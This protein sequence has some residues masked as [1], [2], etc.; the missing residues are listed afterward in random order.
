[1]SDTCRL[2]AADP[3]LVGDPVDTFTG[4]VLDRVLDFRLTG[5]IELRWWRHYDSSQCAR[6]FSMGW[7]MAHDYER[8]LVAVD[9]HSMALDEPVGRRLV[10][11]RL[12]ADGD[13]VARGGSILVRCA[14]NHYVVQR[15]GEPAMEFFF[16]RGAVRARLR[17]LIRDGSEIRFEHDEQQRLIRIVDAAG[18]HIE[19]DE[20]ADGSL[21]RL[22]LAASADAPARLLMAYRYDDRGCLVA[23]EN[24]DGHGHRFAWDVERRLVLRRGRKG[25]QFRFAY[26][27]QGRCTLAVGDDRLHGVALDYQVPARMTRVVRPD[28]GAWIYR[29]TQTGGLASV[30]DPL[31]GVRR[32]VHDAA[33][34]LLQEIDPNGNVSTYAYD[35]AGA[36]VARIDPLGYRL[37]WPD[38]PNGP[39]PLLHRLAANPAEYA[40]GRL[41]DTGAI[42]LPVATSALPVDPAV[43]GAVITRIPDTTMDG[44]SAF[45]TG[46][47]GALWWPEP[48]WG[49]TFS[50]LGKLIAQHDD[51]GNVRRWQYD[52]AGNLAEYCDFDG[53]RWCYDHG[54]WH[55]LRRA[56]D[57][58]GSEV[59]FDYTEQGEVASFQDAG[60]A[61]STYRY[62]LCDRLIEVHR[63]GALRERYQR[64]LA[65]NLVAK[66]GADGR[67]L[68]RIEI[69]P[70]NLPLRRVL[71]SGDVHEFRHDRAGQLL[72]ADTRCDRV[73][74]FYDRFCNRSAELRDGRGVVHDFA[75]LN[76]L[77]RS[78]VLDRFVI[79]HR[80]RADGTIE[81]TD[82][83][84]QRHLVCL[85]GD[86]LIERRL[87][88]GGTEWAQYDN[89]GR[90]L[91]KS[92][93]HPG[94]RPWL[95]RY[96]WSGE[97]ELRRVQDN[98]RGDVLHDYDAAHRLRRRVTG[99]R[100]D[101]FVLDAA[102]N[103]LGQ[104]GLS[105]VTLL[106][107]NR[108]WQANGETF[109]HDDRHHLR[110]RA[111][112][113][114]QT[115]Y[116][117]DS[118]DQLVRIDMPDGVWQ[119]CYDAIGRRTRKIWQG[120]ITEYYWSTDQLIAEI[121]PDGRVRLYVYADTLAQVPLV[122][123][124]YESSD[125][126]ASSCRR[127]HVIAD[128]LGA[129]IR[130]EDDGGHPVWQAEHGPFGAA[131]VAVGA[132]VACHLRAPGH[133][134]DVETGLHYNRRR[135]FDPVLGRYLQ[136]DPWGITGGHNLYAYPANPLLSTDLRG[137][138]D[139]GGRKRSRGDE[140]SEDNRPLQERKGWVDEYGEQKKVTGDGSV[141]RDHQ[142]SKAAIKAAALDEINRRVDAGEMDRPSAA[143]MKQINDRIDKE[144]LSVVVDRDVH[145]AGDTHGHK[146]DAARINQDAQDL[147]RA[148]NRDA[149]SMVRNAQTLDPDNVPSYQAA[150]DQ[151]KTQTHESIMGGV[152]G[153]I[154]DIMG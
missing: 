127:Y 87:G 132:S 27:A 62:D 54:A 82:P 47:L 59:R 55:F 68:L 25:F 137:L 148:A 133:Y 52:A 16:V 96:H 129:P 138:G 151:I 78:T 122:I 13:R 131:T 23:T 43:R 57:P 81:I 153:I 37:K 88:H 91:F 116:S 44:L 139:E 19:V 146:N 80:R 94:R 24:V 60:G 112:P 46:P 58:L 93:Q 51:R 15:H 74:F 66:F 109:T 29:F 111:G 1:M 26:D 119:A 9:A 56:I 31:G 61:V 118:R 110:T 121:D 76:V 75:G 130:L 41:I 63:H 84:G 114:G 20:D 100:V 77:M 103:L 126:P 144:A 135:Y 149:D 38:D 83:G 143:Q 92:L 50:A 120:R 53:Q 140:D 10:F 5:P 128:Q 22:G 104:P 123:L 32:Y 71:A 115:V 136:S 7:G 18:R 85:R 33:G 11:P 145:R 95:R 99:G 2:T 102:G 39:D 97:G 98:E 90:C 12:H 86:G 36:V 21:R 3:R 106:P 6:R 42:R 4:A 117:H 147:G 154:D 17:R 105:G 134:H 107:G 141:D 70:G 108:L 64:D 30:S 40:V 49:R 45:D 34:R 124:D 28:L 113:G 79:D 125:A 150:A 101:E 73:A 69:G 48:T 152:N 72:A 35:S 142:P 65:G 8:S 14:A 89:L 67:E